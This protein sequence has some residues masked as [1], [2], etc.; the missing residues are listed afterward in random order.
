MEFIR[1]KRIAIQKAFFMREKRNSRRIH[2]IYY[3]LV[4][5]DETNQLIG[6][7][8]DMATEGIKLMSK[9]PI[10]PNKEYRFRMLLPSEMEGKSKQI[11]FNVKCVWSQEKLYSDF[12][13]SGFQFKDI[14]PDDIEIIKDLIGQF[15]YQD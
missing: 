2:L 10:L 14:S 6:H 11:T 4:F 13:G 1:N 9:E 5:N 7:V 12:Y 8:V 3:L 15:G